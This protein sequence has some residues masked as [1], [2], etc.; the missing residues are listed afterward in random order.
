MFF[1]Q[2]CYVC[3]LD[4]H[5]H[6]TSTYLIDWKRLGKAAYD[7]NNTTTPNNSSNTTNTRIQANRNDQGKSTQHIQANRVSTIVKDKNVEDNDISYDNDNSSLDNDNITEVSNYTMYSLVNSSN[8]SICYSN[9]DSSHSDCTSTFT[10]H[11]I[12]TQT[13]FEKLLL[14]AHNKR[15]LKTKCSKY[16]HT[17]ICKCI[18]IFQLTRSKTQSI[19]N[20]FPSTP[21][22]KTSASTLISSK[23]IIARISKYLQSPSTI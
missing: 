16:F 14:L 1:S 3:R 22:I 9:V 18:R 2:G 21:T 12:L 7:S 5:N 6:T 8:Y 23:I 13:N 20:I 4:N 10:H 19:P 11:D 15:T 17:S